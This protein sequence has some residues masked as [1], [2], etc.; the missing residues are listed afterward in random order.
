MHTIR[1]THFFRKEKMRF[2]AAHRWVDLFSHLRSQ[3]VIS[4]SNDLFYIWDESLIEFKTPKNPKK[5]FLSYFS[6]SQCRPRGVPCKVHSSNLTVLYNGHPLYDS[7]IR[8]KLN[9]SWLRF[10]H[11]RQ[12][13]WK[14]FRKWLNI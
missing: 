4:P 13:H 10:D 12:N 5:H 6:R 11:F 2:F 1:Y 14:L 9:S 8:Q 7:N 3:S